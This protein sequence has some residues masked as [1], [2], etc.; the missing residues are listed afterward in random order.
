M[1]KPQS[2]KMREF[3]VRVDCNGDERVVNFCKKVC[4]KYLLVHH[5]TTTENPHFHFY[6]STTMSQGN[7]SNK[8]KS[9]LDVKGGDYCVQTCDSDRVLEYYS[10]LFN[11]KKDNEPRLVS[12]EGFSPI[13]IE[14]YR[15]NANAIAA[16]FQTRMTSKKKT[17]YDI[18]MVVLERLDPKKCIFAETIYDVVIEVLRESHTM[19]RPNHVK[20]IIATVMAYSHDK[21]ARQTI[22]DLTLKFFSPM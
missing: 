12:Y 16:E 18:S 20:D 15:A 13:D 1:P 4:D 11:T 5:I 22:K 17:Q 6:C 7:F 10:Y 9:I 19:A 3:R 8:I 21:K 14:I 2:T